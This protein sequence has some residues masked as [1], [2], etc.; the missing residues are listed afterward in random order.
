MHGHIIFKW[1]LKQLTVS[2]AAMVMPLNMCIV[3]ESMP[4]TNTPP[5]TSA[6]QVQPHCARYLG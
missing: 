1:T 3:S 4:G 6:L 5:L 2:A